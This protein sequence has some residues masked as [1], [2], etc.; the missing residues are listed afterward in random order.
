MCAFLFCTNVK[1][2]PELALS[3]LLKSPSSQTLSTGN[4]QWTSR[5]F[6][7]VFVCVVFTLIFLL[8]NHDFMRCV[9]IATGHM[10]KS[11]KKGDWGQRGYRVAR[12]SLANDPSQWISAMIHLLEPYFQQIL[13]VKKCIQ[14]V[15]WDDFFSLWREFT[16][17]TTLW[18]VKKEKDLPANNATYQ[19]LRIPRGCFPQEDRWTE[20]GIVSCHLGYR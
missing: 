10:H 13:W 1:S 11:P 14:Y 9:I 3:K 18:M 20:D 6:S 5:C 12:N 15:T 19:S 7:S 8:S 2:F 17:G 16:Q 4:K